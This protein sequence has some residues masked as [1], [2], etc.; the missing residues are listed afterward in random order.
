MTIVL[1]GLVIFDLLWHARTAW[2][3]DQHAKTINQLIDRVGAR[4]RNGHVD[5][6]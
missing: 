3:L 4:Q 6:R 5:D 1:M 2:E